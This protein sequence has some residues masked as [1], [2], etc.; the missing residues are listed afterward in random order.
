L[1]DKITSIKPEKIFLFFAILFGTSF[2]IVTPPYQSP[3]ENYHFFQAYTISEFYT[4][5]DNGIE[6]IPEFYIKIDS[7]FRK[8]QNNS[9]IKINRDDVTLLLKQRQD[10]NNRRVQFK[11]PASHYSF[12]LYVPQVLGIWTGKLFSVPPIII[13]YLGRFFAMIFWI[14][15]VYFAIK[16]IPI[17]KWLFFLI[18]ITPISLF[19]GA[20]F[21]A[22]SVLNSVSFLLIAIILGYAFDDSKKELKMRDI[23]LIISLSVIITMSKPPYLLLLFAYFIIPYGK[24]KNKKKYY[25]YFLIILFSN[26]LFLYIWNIFVRTPLI[27]DFSTQRNQISDIFSNPIG[28]INIF[29]YTFIVRLPSHLQQ[30]VGKLGWLD[31]ALPNAVVVLYLIAIIFIAIFDKSKIK[32]NVKLT[33]KLL[34]LSILTAM[35]IIIFTLFYLVTPKSSKVIEGIQSRYFIPFYPLLVLLFYNEKCKLEEKWIKLIAISISFITLTSAL[36][37]LIFRYYN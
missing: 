31:V 35:L 36:I 28:F 26:L 15:M 13:F 7:M 14:A 10:E 5:S 18:V 30:I 4:N 3:D 33:H 9:E 6:N 2:L 25:L 11:C 29:F 37:S 12:L 8:M 32:I 34:F 23:I 27:S 24:L 19:Q 22:D 20:S 21:S 16:I 17:P 1:K